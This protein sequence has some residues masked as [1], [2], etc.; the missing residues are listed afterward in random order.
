MLTYRGELDPDR[1]RR[2][3][4]G[5]LMMSSERV[6][7]INHTMISRLEIL[8][9]NFFQDKTQGVSSHPRS[10]EL[11]NQ[12]LLRDAS[13]IGALYDELKDDNIILHTHTHTP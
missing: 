12:K 1:Q 5:S 3:D 10:K 7:G 4:N 11:F 9:E 8:A 6:N 2:K 13:S